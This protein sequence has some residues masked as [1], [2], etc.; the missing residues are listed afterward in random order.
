MSSQGNKYTEGWIAV[1]SISN[2]M[3]ILDNNEKVTGVKIIP[4]NIYKL[5]AN[6]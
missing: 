3:V 6:G 4:K 2:G 1:K 5:R